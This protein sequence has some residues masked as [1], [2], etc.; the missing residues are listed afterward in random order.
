MQSTNIIPKA[1]SM[2]NN[3]L[4]EMPLC[5]FLS[6]PHPSRIGNCLQGFRL[7]PCIAI[8]TDNMHVFLF[9]LLSYKKCSILYICSPAICVFH[10]NISW[11]SL[12][13]Q[14]TGII[15]CFYSVQFLVCTYHSLF[16]QSP[17]PGYFS[18]CNKYFA[19]TNNEATSNLVGLYF[20]ITGV[21]FQSKFYKQNCLVRDT[22][23]NTVKAPSVGPQQ[24][25]VLPVIHESRFPVLMVSSFG[26]C[27]SLVSR[28][29]SE[30]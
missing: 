8:C 27:T 21:H 16:N 2:Q 29:D 3:I 5:P 10:N 26:T 15:I 13:H 14:F 6:V 1:K 23:L 24:L 19:M 12:R 4:R 28:N 18:V 25:V 11:K 22:L 7:S 17:M 30:V 20:H 9:S